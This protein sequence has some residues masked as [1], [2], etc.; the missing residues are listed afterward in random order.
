MKESIRDTCRQPVRKTTKF[1]L[2]SDIHLAPENIE[3]GEVTDQ[4]YNGPFDSTLITT[5]KTP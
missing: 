5:T 3:P 2:R 4:Q 1:G